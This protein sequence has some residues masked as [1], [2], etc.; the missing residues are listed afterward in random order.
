VRLKENTLT[1]EER[2]TFSQASIDKELESLRDK[3]SK[4]ETDSYEIKAQL[5]KKDHSMSLEIEDN[6][7]LVNLYRTQCESVETINKR[8]LR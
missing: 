2:A 3:Y 8:T 5:V 1:L 6:R 4:V 7:S